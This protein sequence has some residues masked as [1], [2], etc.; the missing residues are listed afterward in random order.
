VER[1]RGWRALTRPRVRPRGGRSAR[2][3]EQDGFEVR[4]LHQLC[5]LG[6][7][8]TAAPRLA[9]LADRVDGPLAAIAA[10]HAA[11]L[12][13]PD[14]AALQAVAE[15]FAELDALLPATEAAGGRGRTSRERARREC[16]SRGRARR[17][18]AWAV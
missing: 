5:R 14:G 13:P 9:S 7:P 4:A 16:P 15:R 3:R 11:A 6:E 17:R 12:L 8:E 2:S 10:A 18:V 1:R